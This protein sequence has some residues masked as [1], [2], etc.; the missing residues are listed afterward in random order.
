[1]RY[2]S[3]LSEFMASVKRVGLIDTVNLAY[4]RV[5]DS[6]FDKKYNL[7]TSKRLEIDELEI[8]EEDPDVASKGQMYQ[9]TGVLPFR[10]IFQK[11]KL[12]K[13]PVF[14]DYG[15]GKGRTLALAAL[16]G[17]DKVVGVEF[18]KQLCVDAEKNLNRLKDDLNLKTTVVIE[19]TDASKYQVKLDENLF[20]FFY[21]FDETITK[22]VLTNI[23]SSLKEN[24]REAKMV[25]YYP[26]HRKIVESFKEVKIDSQFRY[27]GYDCVIYS[28][29]VN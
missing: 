24:N 15:C 12:P 19:C 2:S 7:D 9:P 23:I 26:I 27:F 13:D 20:Y 28:F 3:F 4:S 16:S 6:N 17:I 18:S 10:K 8:N 1:M 5:I 21:P 22:S 11:I 14:V 29:D 25:Y